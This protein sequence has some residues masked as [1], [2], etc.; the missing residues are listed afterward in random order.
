MSDGALYAFPSVVLPP[1]FISEA[2][3]AGTA[4]DEMYCLKL[5]ENTGVVVVP[6]AFPRSLTQLTFST[7][8]LTHLNSTHPPTHSLNSTPSLLHFS[9]ILRVNCLV[10]GS[11]FGQK[12]GTWHFRTTFLPPEEKLAGVMKRVETFHADFMASYK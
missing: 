2:E 10:V 8:S 12:D 5:L 7:H 3:A 6:G 9:V 1:K 4:A 11:G